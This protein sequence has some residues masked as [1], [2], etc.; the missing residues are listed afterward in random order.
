GKKNIRQLND[1][2]S[3]VTA[4]G[5]PSAHFEHDIAVVNGK[6]EILSTF[7]YVEEALRKK[8]IT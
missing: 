8:A 1:G 7:S 5:L 2:W 6:P 3:I 4:D